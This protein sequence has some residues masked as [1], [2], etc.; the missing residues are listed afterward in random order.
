MT[1]SMNT[2]TQLICARCGLAFCLLALFPFVA[3]GL[4]PPVS[5]HLTAAQV[6]HHY[7]AHRTLIRL[8]LVIGLFL[9]GLLLP[10]FG[11]ITVQLRRIERNNPVLAMTQLCAGAVTFMVV[12]LPLLVL[13]A[14]ALRPDRAPQ[15]TLAL[16][17][18]GWIL[19]VVPVTS[20]IVQALCIGFA[21]LGDNSE[22][23]VF[24]R[25]VAHVCFLDVLLS[26]PA[27]LCVF[28]TTGPFAWQGA[29]TFYL[30]AVGVFGNWF[31]LSLVLPGAIRQE[32]PDRALVAT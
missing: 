19:L 29:V 30:P 1:I 21:V 20:V 32:S 3:A 17:D 4:I 13:L 5:E 14:A 9:S 15:T 27:V 25:W 12:L 10:F 16:N 26:L 22:Q 24:P 2:R 11:V 6:V 31:V 18:L 8:G 7:A 23:P 28:F